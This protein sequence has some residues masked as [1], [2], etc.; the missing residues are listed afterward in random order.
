[1]TQV[2]VSKVASSSVLKGNRLYQQPRSARK[3]KLLEQLCQALRSR[4]YSLRTEQMYCLWIT[5]EWK[6]ITARPERMRHY[7]G[8]DSPLSREEKKRLTPG[9]SGR[10]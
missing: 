10:W 6:T 1:M 2:E 8:R 7:H 5:G 9:S 3:P 4:Q